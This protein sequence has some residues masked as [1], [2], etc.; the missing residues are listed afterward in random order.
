MSKP[1]SPEV[2]EQRAI[3]R[4]VRKY[5]DEA[6]SKNKGLPL[7]EISFSA[8]IKAKIREEQMRNNTITANAAA[9]KILNSNRF[10]NAAERSRY[11][12]LEAMKQIAP[13]MHKRLRMKAR[14][15]KGKFIKFSHNDLVWNRDL[16]A[17]TYTPYE[18]GKTWMIDTTNSP[19]GYDLVEV[20]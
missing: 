17:Y 5:L 13:E 7:T 9:K 16:G 6:M 3:D 1:L 12:L 8:L 11:N 4:V 19:L 10:T 15:A 18:G 14:D 2:K 20:K